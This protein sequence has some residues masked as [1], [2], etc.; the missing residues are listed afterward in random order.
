VLPQATPVGTLL[1]VNC[2]NARYREHMVMSVV[3]SGWRQWQGSDVRR[4]PKEG[5]S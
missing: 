2:V 5:S 1:I 3:S 4:S